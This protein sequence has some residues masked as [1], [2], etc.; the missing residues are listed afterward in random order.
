M[1]ELD[2]YVPSFM[3]VLKNQIRSFQEDLEKVK[4]GE[5]FDR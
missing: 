1:F 5:K 2:I 4:F 3:D